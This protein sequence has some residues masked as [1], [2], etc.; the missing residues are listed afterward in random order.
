MDDAILKLIL[1]A[2]L[3]GIIGF[4]REKAHRPAGLRT[5]MIVCLSSCLATLVGIHQHT[6]PLRLAANVLTGIGFIGAGTI[7]ATSENIKGITTAATIF[8]VACI[9]IA[10]GAGLYILSIFFTLLVFVILWIK[11]IEKSDSRIFGY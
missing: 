8:S 7:I 4:E 2:I 5:H 10:V 11:N 3:G 9:G 6:D 1:S